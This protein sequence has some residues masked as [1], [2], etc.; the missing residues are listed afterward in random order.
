MRFYSIENSEEPQN[1]GSPPSCPLVAHGVGGSALAKAD[2]SAI[3]ASATAE[4]FPNVTGSRQK[5]I[6]KIAS[7]RQ[8]WVLSGCLAPAKIARATRLAKAQITKGEKMNADESPNSKDS[9]SGKT[10]WAFDL[11]K[12]SLGE[13]VR[14]GDILLDIVSSIPDPSPP[15]D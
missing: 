8:K 9:K 2:L 1:F 7:F 15:N 4:A 11:G 12:G 10:I 3:A 6:H 14:C 13:A 5:A